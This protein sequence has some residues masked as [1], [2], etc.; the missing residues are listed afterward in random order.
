MI[1]NFQKLHFSAFFQSNDKHLRIQLDKYENIKSC[2]STIQNFCMH[3]NIQ[4]NIFFLQIC[5]YHL[6]LFAL[7][8]KN[9][10]IY[11]KY[12]CNQLLSFNNLIPL[13]FI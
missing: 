9:M 7:N 6:F 2:I 8:K 12:N 1:S 10:G 4:T 13:Y 3:K 11:R 5:I